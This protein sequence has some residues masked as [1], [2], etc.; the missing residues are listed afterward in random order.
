MT[1][2]IQHRIN[3]PMNYREAC[4]YIAAHY[5]GLIQSEY[6]EDM[7]SME[8]LTWLGSNCGQYF[9]REANELI[10]EYPF[11]EDCN[12]AIVCGEIRLPE[13]VKRHKKWIKEK[14]NEAP[15]Y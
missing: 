2:K 10:E 1:P 14:L 7:N 15:K 9:M 5:I 13:V 11:K 4:Y 8:S 3:D 12:F 6:L